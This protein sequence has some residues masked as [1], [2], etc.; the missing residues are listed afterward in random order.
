[1]VRYFAKQGITL[2][3]YVQ[4]KQGAWLSS[5]IFIFSKTWFCFHIYM[6]CFIL[7]LITVS[8]WIYSVNVLYLLVKFL[9]LSFLF[10]PMDKCDPFFILLRMC[11]H[12]VVVVCSLYI[13]TLQV[14]ICMSC[15][16]F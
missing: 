11:M 5:F 9:L 14:Y 10:I 4:W 8:R 2:T 15:L 1:V 12:I 13:I 3:G 6:L 7:I 16:Y